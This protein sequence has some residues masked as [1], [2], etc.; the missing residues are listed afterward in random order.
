MTAITLPRAARPARFAMPLRDTLALAA[1]VAGPLAA[2]GLLVPFRTH[3]ASTNLALI[4]VVVV[5]AVAANGHRGAGALAALSSAVWFDFLL[6]RPYE[7][8][9]IAGGDDITTAVLLLAVGLAVSQLAAR[10]RR[11]KV[12]TVTDADH[13]ARIHD[14]AQLAR[15]TGSAAT[16]VDHVRGELTDVLHLDGCRFEYGSLLGHPPQLGQDGEVTTAHGRWS[17]ERRGWPQG[18]TELRVFGNGH[19]YGRFML[20]PGR[21][22]VVP[23]Q[24]RL[25]AATLADQVG[26]A[27]ADSGTGAG[28]ES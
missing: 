8:F 1:A 23:L 21:A 12:V 22:D 11:L 13:L 9:T 2:A 24:A 20:R 26:A 18:E 7:R 4:L 17:L 14:T 25:V 10:A 16:V 19:Y 3:V 5:V 28:K 6:T 27:L 15:R